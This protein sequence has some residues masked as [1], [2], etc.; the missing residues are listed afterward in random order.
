MKHAG[1][2]VALLAAGCVSKID[3]PADIRK[4]QHGLVLGSEDVTVDFYFRPGAV[5]RPHAVVA[6]GFLANKGRMAHWGLVLAREGFV[7]A[8][9]TNPTYA[10]D[11][12]NVAALVALVENGRAGRWP[13]SARGDGRV[14]LVGFS[15]GGFET[16]LA[17]AELGDKVDAWVGLDPVDRGA[18]GKAA[19]VKVRLPGLALVADPQPLNA[20]GNARPM[21][22]AYAGPLEV[23][24]VRGAGHLDGESP[25]RGGKFPEFER[26]VVGFLRRVF[27]L[28][29]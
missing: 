1:L 11:H 26:A 7:V 29:R 24:A 9:P 22:D 18:K 15:R 12:R 23:I 16:M 3:L 27:V 28:P 5:R 13:V 14:V 4:E 25:R 6:H 20:N 19:A 2:V 10:D 17:A 21:L 8:V